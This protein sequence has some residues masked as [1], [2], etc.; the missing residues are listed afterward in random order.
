MGNASFDLGDASFGL[1]DASL[2]LDVSFG[3]CDALHFQTRA[4]LADVA[5]SQVNSGFDLRFPY[6]LKRSKISAGNAAINSVFPS[7]DPV[8]AGFVAG[9]SH[10]ASTQFFPPFNT[11]GYVAPNLASHPSAIATG[12]SSSYTN[13]SIGNSSYAT[14]LGNPGLFPEWNFSGIGIGLDSFPPPLLSNVR[15]TTNTESEGDVNEPR[16]PAHPT[17][18]PN[19]QQSVDPAP[20]PDT[21]SAT[22]PRPRPRVLQRNTPVPGTAPTQTVPPHPIASTEKGKA[23]TAKRAPPK[24]ALPKTAPSKP[25]APNKQPPPKPFT[26]NSP[27][28]SVIPTKMASQNRP[29]QNETS[30]PTNVHSNPSDAMDPAG[31]RAS[32]RVPKKSTCN[33][34]ANAIGTNRTS[35]VE[36]GV[37]DEAVCQQKP[38]SRKAKRA[39]NEVQGRAVKY[40]YF[41]NPVVSKSVTDFSAKETKVKMNLKCTSY[42]SLSCQFVYSAVVLYLGQMHIFVRF[43]N[44]AVW[45]ACFNLDLP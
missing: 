37:C 4:S 42:S 34:A 44:M 31:P 8:P 22:I 13:S 32:K 19:S 26:S 25:A 1:D 36:A 27:S 16:L 3:L 18:P 38:A 14:G 17:L 12:A 7:M 41:G 23:D 28:P 24:P 33:E 30:H 2:G 15:S 20:G 29:T 10:A 43:G 35:F 5:G 9:V 6:E 45:S 40:V 21:S 11:N 39:G